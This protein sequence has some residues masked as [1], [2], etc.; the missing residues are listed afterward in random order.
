MRS[1]EPAVGSASPTSKRCSKC[2]DEKPIGEFSRNAR[3][4]DGRNL[5]CKDC[6]QRLYLSTKP[7]DYQLQ[8]Y[9]KF[10][11]VLR[12]DLTE[13]RCTKCGEMRPREEYSKDSKYPDGRVKWC[14]DCRKAH[15]A[16]LAK[17][18]QYQQAR[19]RIWRT[20][21][22][23]H[24]ERLRAHQKEAQAALRRE[25]ISAYGARCVC[26]GETT[27]EFLAIDHVH[28][29]GSRHRRDVIGPGRSFYLWLKRHGYPADE[30]RV[31]CH[32]CNAARGYYGYCPH[33][34]DKEVVA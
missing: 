14:R 27:F 9:P 24:R 7:P 25:V 19:E 6:C 17:L 15:R 31:L 2:T 4:K 11:N 30:F 29:G 3:R 8:R 34:R 21:Y 22:S 10:R 13:K 23:R 5:W 20:Y 33:E 16:E 12:P 26:C 18:K 1:I 32:N 28:G